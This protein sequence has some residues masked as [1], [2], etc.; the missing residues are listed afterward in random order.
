MRDRS[1][2]ERE[3]RQ[4]LELVLRLRISN[5]PVRTGEDRE[6]SESAEKFSSQPETTGKFPATQKSLS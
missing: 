6:V 3:N 4:G 2:N 1:R 5:S